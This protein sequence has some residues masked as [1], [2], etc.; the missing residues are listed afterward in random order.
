MPQPATGDAMINADSALEE[1][2]AKNMIAAQDKISLKAFP[3]AQNFT[4]LSDVVLKVMYQNP[5]ILGVEGFEYNYGT[6]TL[7]IHY[8]ESAS[9]IRRSK[10]R[11]LLKRTKSW[12]LLSK[13]A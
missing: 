13:T 9:G 4:T 8:N 10:M 7:S 11:L 1:V 3:E 6:L 2:L 12:L 5:L